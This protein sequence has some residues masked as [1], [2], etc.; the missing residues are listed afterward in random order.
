ML[1][2]GTQKVLCSPQMATMCKDDTLIPPSLFNSALCLCFLKPE[3]SGERSI[4]AKARWEKKK[5]KM[6]MK[7]MKEK[8]DE[9]KN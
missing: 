4:G 5:K 9:K 8:E 1:T 3:M 7:K 6:K 2:Q